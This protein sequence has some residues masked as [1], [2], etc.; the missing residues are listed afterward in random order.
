[1]EVSHRLMTRSYTIDPKLRLPYRSVAEALEVIPRILAQNCGA[2]V[3]VVCGWE[4]ARAR[5]GHKEL[6]PSDTR[7]DGSV[8]LVTTCC[9][10]C[11][12]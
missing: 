10:S 7:V 6:D 3:R 11:V 2:P 9:R 5:P 12:S 4:R 1:M 8:A